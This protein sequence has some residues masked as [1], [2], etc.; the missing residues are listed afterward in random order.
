MAR[1]GHFLVDM[2]LALNLGL[3]LTGQSLWLVDHL[4]LLGALQPAGDP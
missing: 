1:K 4:H 3:L 2:L